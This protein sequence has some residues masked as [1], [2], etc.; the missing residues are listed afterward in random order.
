MCKFN[1]LIGFSFF[2]VGIT[3]I[4]SIIGIFNQS[5]AKYSIGI[6]TMLIEIEYAKSME[7]K[8]YYP[9]YVAYEPSQFNY[10][11]RLADAFDFYDWYSK[12]WIPFE[13]RNKKTRVNE[14]FNQKMNI[15]KNWL[16]T[17]HLT[18]I[19]LFYPYFYMGSMYPKSDCVKSVQHLLIQDFDIEGLYY[20]V[21]FNPEKMELMLSGVTVHKYQFEENIDFS[22]VHD[23][24]KWSRV[25]L[26][27]HPQITVRNEY[28]LYAGYIFLQDLFRQHLLPH[29]IPN[30]KFKNPNLNR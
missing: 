2:D 8:Y 16:N 1:Y 29:P 14:Y 4:A 18:Y 23:N 13:K 19:S 22:D 10:K 6:Y 17:F 24:E 20:I 7:L 9:G 5:Y 11:L 15:A 25:L 3:S 30:T 12:R 26:Y 28:E 27:L 21:E